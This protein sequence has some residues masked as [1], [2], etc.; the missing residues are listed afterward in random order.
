MYKIPCIHKNAQCRCMDYRTNL[1]R[2]DVSWIDTASPNDEIN[3]HS[4]RCIVYLG[5]EISPDKE[6][7]EFE[8]R[9]Y[10]WPCAFSITVNPVMKLNPIEVLIQSVEQ[11]SKQWMS[12]QRSA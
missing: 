1:N 10:W 12:Y 7:H 4:Y 6:I 9:S 11:W 5:V 8:A 3:V 2:A